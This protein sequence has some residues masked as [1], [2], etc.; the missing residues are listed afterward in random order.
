MKSSTRRSR[1]I[2]EIGI[3]GRCLAAV[4]EAF[5]EDLGQAGFEDLGT[6]FFDVVLDSAD[7]DFASHI[8]VD[9]VARFGILVAGLAD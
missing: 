1:R 2:T 7:L 3:G 4:F 9:G 6:G 5:G 8:I